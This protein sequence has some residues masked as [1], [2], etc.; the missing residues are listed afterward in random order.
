MSIDSLLMHVWTI[1]MAFLQISASGLWEAWFCP[2]YLNLACA[3][4]VCKHKTMVRPMLY[5]SH[6]TCPHI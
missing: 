6:H 1:K 5:K 4:H 3:A 2:N